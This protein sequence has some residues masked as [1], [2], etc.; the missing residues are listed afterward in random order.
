MHICATR[1]KTTRELQR[2]FT[3]GAGRLFAL[4]AG[5]KNTTNCIH[6][7]KL[8]QDAAT[9]CNLHMGTYMLRS[10]AQGQV[11]FFIP[12]TIASANTLPAPG[13]FHQHAVN[14]K[15]NKFNL[16]SVLMA[17]SNNTQITDAIKFHGALATDQRIE[18]CSLVDQ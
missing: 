16:R 5:M 10:C 12:A 15:D 18:A 14:V 4:V 13:E 6:L 17:R 8:E 2:V 11:V 3:T 9:T 1:R 7:H